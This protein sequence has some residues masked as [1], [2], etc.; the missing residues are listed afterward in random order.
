MPRAPLL[1]LS[2]IAFSACSKDAVSPDPS[3]PKTLSYVGTYDLAT[4]N[5]GGLPALYFENAPGLSITGA[6]I[7]LRADNSFTET[8]NYSTYFAASGVTQL[9]TAIKNGIYTVA[10][11]QLTFILTDG[12]GGAAGL[13]YTGAVDGDNLSYKLDGNLYLY[14]RTI[15][16]MIAFATR[17]D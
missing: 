9:D 1:L 11:S 12:I 16:G 15:A 6:T 5:N 4:V 14:R 3:A 17:S 13:S 7:T 2:L 10:G 8:R